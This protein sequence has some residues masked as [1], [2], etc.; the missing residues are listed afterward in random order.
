MHFIWTIFVHF[1]VLH[2]IFA[3]NL[4]ENN[5]LVEIGKTFAVSE[6]TLTTVFERSLLGCTRLCSN[7]LNCL[8]GIFSTQNGKCRLDSGR[9]PL[10]LSYN[11]HIVFTKSVK[12]GIFEEHCV[13][14]TLLLVVH[15]VT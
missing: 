15:G 5:F 8:S 4:E 12:K 14:F 6:T 2:N 7:D 10:T 9:N 3:V 13:Y 11:S 1:L